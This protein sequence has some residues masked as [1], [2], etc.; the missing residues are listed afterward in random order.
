MPL[1]YLTH[2]VAPIDAE[3]RSTPEDFEV[4]E[5]PVYAPSG[6]GEHIF[7]LIEKRG[8]TTK[9]AVRLL[10]EHVDADP[11]SAGWAGLKDRHAVTR[12]WI[13]IWGAS[14]DALLQAE[15]EGIRVLEAVPHT[16]KLR[17]GHLRANRFR[18][19][20]R[21]VDP[22]RIDD[23]RSLL[24]DIQERG[25]PNYYGEQRFGR[26]GDN[27]RRALTWVVGDARAPRSPFHRKLQMSAV[28]SEIF[29]RCVAERVQSSTLGK[30]FPGDLVKKHE[31]GGLFVAPDVEDTQAR[32]DAWEISPTGPMFGTKM[33]WPEG[34]A[35]DREEALLEQSGL[36]LEALAKWKR[37]APGTRRF[38]R[39]PVPELDLTVSDSTVELDFTL[40]A[41]SYATI[42]VRE[43]LKRD[44]PPPKTG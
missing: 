16:Q 3:F 22:A 39:V 25:L 41:G 26:D 18:I 7:A 2:A 23:L 43:I 40:P 13:S 12:Q 34:E 5:V 1:P 38:V 11:R 31:S 24:S 28:Q 33:R 20:L 17:T 15:V 44:A 10:C 6:S 32:A 14:P 37:L 35:R 29:N 21:E 4:E 42:L 30:I 9:D 8:L 27:A 19:R 36:T